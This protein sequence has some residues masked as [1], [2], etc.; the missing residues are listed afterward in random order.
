MRAPQN[1]SRVEFPTAASLT[2]EELLERRSPRRTPYR[3]GLVFV[4]NCSGA[5]DLLFD[6]RR[7]AGITDFA[8]TSDHTIQRIGDCNFRI[9]STSGGDF[10]C[11]SLQSIGY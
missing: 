8:G 2:R 11:F 3:T 4:A 1:N 6:S 7:V 5:S 9:A 10:G